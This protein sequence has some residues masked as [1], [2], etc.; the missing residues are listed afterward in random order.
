MSFKNKTIFITGAS[1][2]I[3][4]AMALKLAAEGA[5]I[6][7]GAK[8]VEE[9]PRLGGTIFS[10][11]QEVEA[12]GG[13]GLAIQL[14][15]RYEDQIQAAMEKAAAHFGGI[16]VVINN[17]SAIQLT[18]TDKTESKRF[19]LMH[20]INVRGTFLMVKHALP[21]LR[22][23]NNPHILT[24][25]PPINLDPKWLAGHV[26]YTVSKYSMSMM[27]LG[28][29]AEFKADGIASNA[30]WPRTTIDTAAVRNLLGGQALANMSRTPDIIADAAHYILSQ[31]AAECTGN[32]FID[33]DVL[34][35]AG[36]TDLE[37]YSV[38]PGATLY[39]DLFV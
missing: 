11:A 27:A 26:A 25:S 28:W 29:A 33:E 12:A 32:T 9:D 2:G 21:F 17:A 30:L 18:P 34:A 16:D 5:Q 10:A 39:K 23:G 8:S 6:V 4:K 20:D 13:K 36:I 14:D 7:I 31:P 19:D 1:R 38:V 37:K 22:K 35:K 3:G 15:I 24:L